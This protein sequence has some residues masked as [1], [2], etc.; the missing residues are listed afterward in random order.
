MAAGGRARVRAGGDVTHIEDPPILSSEL[1]ATITSVEVE[2][3]SAGISLGIVSPRPRSRGV[4]PFAFLLEG[5]VASDTDVDRLEVWV[6]NWKLREVSVKVVTEHR[7]DPAK[8]SRGGLSLYSFSTL[9][10]TL[11]MPRSFRASIRV[12]LASG[13]TVDACAIAG[14]RPALVLPPGTTPRL[15]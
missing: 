8:S 6:G 11:R 14:T 5:L 12:V 13:D 3:S 4:L 1:E 9:V 10:G 15:S 7:G 2:R